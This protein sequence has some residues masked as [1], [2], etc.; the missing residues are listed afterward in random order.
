[1]AAKKKV[2]KSKAVANKIAKPAA[3]KVTKKTAKPAAKKGTK[4]AAKKRTVKKG[5]LTIPRP[6]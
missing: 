3:K 6:F 5:G 1:M 4:P 2:S